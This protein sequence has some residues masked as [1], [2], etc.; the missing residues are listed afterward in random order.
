MAI[1]IGLNPPLE[2][3]PATSS[4]KQNKSRQKQTTRADPAQIPRTAKSLRRRS[5]GCS[6]SDAVLARFQRSPPEST[7]M[8]AV[9]HEVGQQRSDGGVEEG[10]SVCFVSERDGKPWQSAAGPS[11]RRADKWCHTLLFPSSHLHQDNKSRKRQARIKQTT[12]SL[13]IPLSTHY[14]QN[15]QGW[16]VHV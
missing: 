2:H 14:R 8:A 1:N 13:L 6:L 11:S 4:N 5:R 7:R 10:S 12:T 15:G 9:T 3:T 16:Y